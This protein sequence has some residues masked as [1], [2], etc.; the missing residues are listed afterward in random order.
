M[1][2]N[3]DLLLDLDKIVSYDKPF[4]LERGNDSENPDHP[5]TIHIADSTYW[6]ASRRERDVD[7]F[8]LKGFVGDIQEAKKVKKLK[9]KIN[10]KYLI[11]NL[12]ELLSD[13][14]DYVDLAYASK[15]ELIEMIVH[16]GMFYKDE[17]NKSE[18]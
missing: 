18:E 15:K 13:E 7:F 3:V 10:R 17:Y 16:A 8:L 5:C 1:L 11:D 12:K 4:L 9:I 14:N 2:R 6:Y